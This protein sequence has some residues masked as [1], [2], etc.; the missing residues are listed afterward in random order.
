VIVAM[1]PASAA[2]SV[3]TL[4]KDGYGDPGSPAAEVENEIA[5]GLQYWL[6]VTVEWLLAN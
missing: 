3:P 5:P 2:V 6:P 4:I 1:L